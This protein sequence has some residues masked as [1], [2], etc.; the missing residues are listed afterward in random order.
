[1]FTSQAPVFSIVVPVY[2][3]KD[4]LEKCVDSLVNQT[5]QDFEIILVDDGSTDGCAVMCDE[6]GRVYP[7]IEVIHKKNGG[8]SDARNV[9]MEKAKG[10]YVLFVD[11]DDYLST[12]A[13]ER[14]YPYTQ[15]GCDILVGAAMNMG[16]VKEV[17]APRVPAD[18]VFTNEEYLYYAPVINM[19]ACLSVFNRSFL[20]DNHLSF[21]VGLLHEDE[22]FSPRALL[23]AKKIIYTGVIYYRRTI[24][25]GSISRSKDMS[26]NVRDHYLTMCKLE[27]MFSLIEDDVL[28]KILLD[29]LVLK[30]LFMFQ[31]AKAYQYGDEYI[32]KDFVLRNA[33]TR[34]TKMKA[35]LFCVSPV[36]YWHVNACTK[37][38]AQ[39][40][41]QQKQ[42]KEA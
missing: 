38:L 15:Q 28:K 18:I 20:V 22:D 40:M 12:D 32:H 26:K 39:W 2:N 19:S 24:R 17:F 11:S 14:L 37:K 4:Y 33:C 25:E 41:R 10:N 16:K 5:F 21:E 7:N 8:L 35:M 27:K 29:T 30:Y 13:C 36:I 23:C 31:H 3:V 6:Y 42:Q 9:G 34:K 1:M